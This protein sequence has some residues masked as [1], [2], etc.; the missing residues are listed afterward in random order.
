MSRVKS[1]FKF[2]LK[3]FSSRRNLIIAA[4]VLLL[5]SFIFWPRQKGQ[6]L[7]Y[8]PVQREDIVST[9]SASGILDGKDDVNLHFNSAGKLGSLSVKQGD[10]VQKGDQVASL[11][12]QQLNINLTQAQN[13]L[14][15]AQANVDKVLDDIHLSQYGNGGTGNI[16]SANETE[17]QRLS[18][19]NAETARDS[20]VDSVKA[21]QRAFQDALLFAPL[22]GLVVKSNVVSGQ[23]VTAADTIVQIV[24]DSQI[25]FAADVDESDISQI[26]INQPVNVSLNSYPDQTFKGFIEEISPVTKTT[27]SGAT[28]VT[29]KINLQNPPVNFVVG[30]NGQADIITKEAKNTLTI[31]L[32]ALQEDNTV[33]I[34][35]G[36]SVKSVSVKTGV[37]S[38]SEVQILDGLKEGDQVV[39]NPQAVPSP[40]SGF[41]FPGRS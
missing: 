36:E 21:A 1:L 34:K 23:N 17:T 30:L 28:V 11:D 6:P 24:D 12:M 33:F 41:K 29:V 4:I 26:A 3:T 22:T 37:K 25:I 31:P 20:A 10:K 7:E 19:T 14:R 8:A 2:P 15:A 16:G 9:I 40:K 27:S 32:D 13:N 5:F 38:D 39:K 18:R 35:N